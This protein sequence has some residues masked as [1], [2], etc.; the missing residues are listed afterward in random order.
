[1]RTKLKFYIFLVIAF[2]LVCCNVFG[3]LNQPLKVQVSGI[4][5]RAIVFI[6]GFGCSGD[7]YK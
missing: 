5:K 6:P 1:M 7:V 4:G 2:T 3:Q